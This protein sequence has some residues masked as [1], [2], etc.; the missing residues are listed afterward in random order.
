MG[1]KDKIIEH[2]NRFIVFSGIFLILI[3][4]YVVL[5]MVNRDIINKYDDIIFPSIYLDGIDV[6]NYH[7]DELEDVIESKKDKI[8]SQ[9]MIFVSKNKEVEVSLKEMGLKIDVDHTIKEIDNYQKHLPY[10][11]K[12]WYI[13]GH[14]EMKEFH[15]KYL[16]DDEIYSKFFNTLESKANIAPING[17]FDDSVGVKYV[18]SGTL[19]FVL[20]YAETIA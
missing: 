5:Y 2:K 9:K 10:P 16:I 14:N 3:F 13:N 12:L 18:P 6:S 7:Y 17:Y 15:F 20:T 8:L 11:Q 19:V 4:F 1:M